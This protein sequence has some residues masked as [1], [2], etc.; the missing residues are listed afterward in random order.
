MHNRDQWRRTKCPHPEYIPSLWLQRCGCGTRRDD[1]SLELVLVLVV[2]SQLIHSSDK[3]EEIGYDFRVRQASTSINIAMERGWLWT[4][5]DNGA[6]RKDAITHRF[7][8]LA[9]PVD[10]GEMRSFGFDSPNTLI[11]ELQ[12]RYTFGAIFIN[13]S[14]ECNELS[15]F[16][17]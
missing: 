11:M 2:A 1:L 10:F 4:T 15:V 5:Q 14:T 16:M 8:H 12:S 17:A 9:R 7:I 3:Q 13:K 6:G